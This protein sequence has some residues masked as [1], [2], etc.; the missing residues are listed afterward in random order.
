MLTFK[1]GGIHPPDNKISRNASIEVF[2]VPAIAY[3]GLNQHLGA[4]AKPLVQKGDNVKVG[5]KIA[6]ASSFIS[7][8]IHSP[9]SGTVD[10]IDE[11]IDASGYKVPTII[12][13]VEGDEWNDTIDRTPELVKYIKLSKEEIINKMKELGVVGMGGATFPTHVKYMLP[14]GKKADY[15]IINGVECEPYLTADYRLMLE[16]PDELLIGVQILMKA[17]GVDE[18]YI[19]IENNKPEAIKLLTDKSTLYKGIHVVPLKMK[20]P[21]GAEKQLINAITGREVPSGK[22]PIDVGCVVDNAGTIYAVYQAIQKNMPLFERIVTVTG[23]PVGKPSNYLVRIG[24][25][26]SQLLEASRANYDITGK[27]ISG[28]PMMGKALTS[29]DVAV[30]KGTS[31]ILMMTKAESVRN[32]F[33]NCIRCGKCIDA[34]PMGLEP[35][36]ISAYSRTGNLDKAESSNIMDCIECGCCQFTCPAY[37]P[38]LDYI[39]DGKKKVGA[40]IRN[41]NK[42]K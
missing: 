40:I 33:L 21:Q 13:K 9:V 23:I 5:D 26:V 31:G 10:K 38:L 17:L 29:L 11:W 7:A 16:H 39:R 28:G 24:T 36:L 42:K 4:P 22:L 6:E 18:A 35:Y 19:G 15:L 1:K 12:I 2:P 14:E 34:C 37:R 20:Y 25:P 8:N 3:V 30:T 41:R 32:Q 27:V